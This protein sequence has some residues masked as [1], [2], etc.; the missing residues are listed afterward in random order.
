MKTTISDAELDPLYRRVSWRLMP[1]LFLCYV[2]AYLDRVNVGF[3]KLQMLADLRFSDTVYG[4]GAGIFFIGYFLFE[5]PS[6]LLMTRTG[7]RIWIARIMISWGLISS[8]LMLANSVATFYLLR[9][10][11]GAAEAG[12]FPGIILYLTYWYPAH[13]RARM[14][15]LFMSGVAV[16]G[17]VGGP[18]S[19]W[20]M[21]SFAGRHGLSGWQW[22]FLLEGLPSVLIGVWTLFYLDDGIRA[23][24]WLSEDDKRLLERAIAE[25]GQHQQRLPLARV[26]ASG[27]VWLLALVYFLFVMGLYGVS[28]WLP[29]LIKNSGVKNVFDIGLLTAIPYSVAA[30]AMVLAARHSD[31]SGERRWHAAAAAV[32][33]ALGLVAA[34]VYSDN[35]VIA[36]AA[37]S[38]ATAG[39]LST[40]PIFW[41][42]PTAMLGGAAAAAGIA[43]INSVGNLA[44]FASPYL[45]GAIKDATGSTAN[46]IYLLAASLVA[47]AALVVARRLPGT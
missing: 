18:L 1:F 42:L 19:G 34:T 36:M 40:F 23:A 17:V 31:R 12:F 13:R 6:N 9:F 2:A 11:L 38:V 14:V 16:A 30:V 44:G 7:A 32:A 22:L 35:T 10:L 43:L 28:F 24:R 29:Q 33:G 41:S 37:L 21:Q 4:V 26:F 8:A 15:A 39:I 46:G 25:D 20:I 45:V 5:V 3:A 27:T 47:G